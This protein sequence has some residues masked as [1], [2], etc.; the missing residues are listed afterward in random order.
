MIG[1]IQ[2]GGL[3]LKTGEGLLLS[4][5]KNYTGSYLLRADESDVTVRRTT[6]ILWFMNHVDEYVYYSDQKRGHAIFRVQSDFRSEELL[7]DKPCYKLLINEDWMYYIHENDHKL[8]RSTT[9]KG[10]HETRL[11]DEH[12]DSFLMQDGLMIYA[13]PQGIKTCKEDGTSREV[14]HNAV[15]STLIRVGDKLAFADRRNNGAVSILDLKDGAVEVLDN[16]EASSMNTDGTYLYCANKCHASTIY[17][18]DPQSGRSIRICG[19]SADYVHVIEDQIYYCN[20][21]EWYKLALTGGETMR[22]DL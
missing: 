6:G 5:I 17:R 2:N 18:I 7:I 10:N 22:I 20:N 3:V 15:S 4:D 14:I 8:Y 16:M 13:T 11:I 1:N 21:R 19:E 9:I 12:V